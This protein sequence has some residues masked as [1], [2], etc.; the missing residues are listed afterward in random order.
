V[1]IESL[2]RPEDQAEMLAHHYLQALELAEAAGT[3]AAVLGDS[4]RRALRDA[5][6][7]AAALY[8]ADAAERFYDAALRLW[9]TDDPERPALLFR[10]AAP[11][12]IW[13]GGD[14]ARLGEA[15]DALLAAGDNT[16]AA[17]AEYLLSESFRMQGRRDLAD[18]HAERALALSAGLPPSRSSGWVMMHQ[19]NQAFGA[20]EYERGI[21]LGVQACGLAEQLRSEEALSDAL[22]VLGTARV[23]HG[24]R[25]GLDDLA[26]SI[27]VATRAGAL[28]ALSGAYNDLAAAYQRLGDLDAAYAA[29]AEGARVAERVGSALQ[30]RWFQGAL[31]DAL[32]RRGEWDDALRKG[33]DFLLAVDGGSSHVLTW[34]VSAVR[35]EIRFAQDDSAGAIGDAESALAAGRA[36]GDPEVLC[37]ILSAC[38]HIFSLASERDRATS[39]AREFLQPVSRE[40][41][42]GFSVINLPTF[43]SAARL[44][45]LGN[46]LIDRLADQPHIPWTAAARAYAQGDFV[47]AAEILHQTGSRPEEAEARLRAA[48]Q[49]VDLGRRADADAQLQPALD[50]YR[51]VGATRYIRD[52]EAL[53]TAPAE[54]G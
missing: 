21:E 29:R 35:A 43:A 12:P 46:E 38:A 49:L 28:G 41:A 25:H 5:G 10:R 7:R 27:E 51:S 19:A 37:F 53:R 45:D 3:D 6:D 20:G 23:Q 11:V 17:E 32:Y 2:G 50:F 42:I 44:L 24:D 39:L 18:Q 8:A 26:R 30:I 9:P 54:L 47:A 48:E 15:R 40:V 36:T 13:G 34:Q 1:W 4:A 52:C 33:D 22:T 31:T 16:R 14:P